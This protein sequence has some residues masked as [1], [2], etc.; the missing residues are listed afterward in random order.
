METLKLL[1]R[2]FNVSINT[3]S[4]LSETTYLPVLGNAF[5]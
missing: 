3:L 1:S 5:K 2:E 4:R